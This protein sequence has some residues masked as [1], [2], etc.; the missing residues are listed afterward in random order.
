MIDTIFEDDK[1]NLTSSMLGDSVKNP[2]SSYTSTGGRGGIAVFADST[3]F[4]STQGK[5][6]P[7]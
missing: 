1:E 7:E 4:S 6:M 3:N 2:K 5:T